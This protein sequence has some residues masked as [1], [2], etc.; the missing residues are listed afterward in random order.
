MF[1]CAAL[2]QQSS[3]PTIAAAGTPQPKLQ[4]AVEQ[5]DHIICAL[6]VVPDADSMRQ[7]SQKLTVLLRPQ[8][9]RP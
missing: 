7:A 6:A 4:A 9:H 8:P 5:E 3:S 2:A 1:G